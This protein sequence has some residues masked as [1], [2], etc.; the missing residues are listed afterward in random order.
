M[1]GDLAYEGFI[2]LFHAGWVGSV[3]MEMRED[4]QP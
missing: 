4:E 1:V 2:S 3:W